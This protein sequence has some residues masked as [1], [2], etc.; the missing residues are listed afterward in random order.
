[1]FVGHLALSLAARRA[2]RRTPLVW[3]MVAANLVDLAWPILLIAGI[4]RVRVDPGN[5]AFT[6]LAFDH[7]PWTHSLLMVVVW[8]IALAGLARMRGIAKPTAMIIGAL[9]VSHWVLDYFSHA[10]DLLLWPGGATRFG[11][12]LWDSIPATYAV[13]LILWVTG[14]VLFLGDR[15]P[16]GTRGWIALGSFLLVT[17]VMWAASPFSPPPPDDRA[18]A[19]FSLVG[20]IIVPWAVWI[21]RT[22]VPRAA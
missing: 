22:S 3:Y 16:R 17:T 20:W 8:G 2:D 4:E 7:Y 1:M 14:I 13:E 5:T 15:R 18:I 6:P 9:V 10:P 12:G 11:L 19:Y 21:E